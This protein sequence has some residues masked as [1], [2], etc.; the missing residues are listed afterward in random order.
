MDLLI[1]A[2]LIG[3]LLVLL[4]A[5]ADELLLEWTRQRVRAKSGEALHHE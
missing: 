5:F 2:L 3:L 4:I 1:T